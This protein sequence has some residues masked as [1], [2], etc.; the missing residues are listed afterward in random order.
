MATLEFN[1]SLVR[2]IGGAKTCEDVER[3]MAGALHDADF[4][5]DSYCQAILDR[6]VDFPTGLYSGGV[7][8]AIPHCDIS[9]VNK[10]AMCVGVLKD[11]V[12][13]GRME[14]KTQTCDVRLVAML[15]LTDPKDH[16]ATLR[17]V[18]NLVQDQQLAEHIVKSDDPAEIY[19]LVAEKLAL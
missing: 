17:K 9:H 3:T 14:D 18:M 12:P 8:V 13:W 10:G 16:L 15:A 11:P 19:G 2:I 5:K 7:N 6:E 1:E 4:V